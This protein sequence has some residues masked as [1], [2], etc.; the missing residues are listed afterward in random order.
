MSLISWIQAIFLLKLSDRVEEV[1]MQTHVTKA[2]D[3]LLCTLSFLN[4][5]FCL[6]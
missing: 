3:T 4:H 1:K 2:D 5:S 6:M